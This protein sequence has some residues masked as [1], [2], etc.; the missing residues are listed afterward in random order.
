MKAFFL[1]F[2][3]A[4]VLTLVVVVAGWPARAQ[5]QSEGQIPASGE[6]TT[7]EAKSFSGNIVRENGKLVLKDPVTK[8]IYKLDDPAKA[9]QYVGKRVKVTGKLE[10]NTNT[11]RVETIAAVL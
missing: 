10:M 8:V 6:A 9:R 4:V 5:Q 11:I 1:R 2:S 3:L 7:Q